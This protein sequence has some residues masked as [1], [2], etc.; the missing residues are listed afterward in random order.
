MRGRVAAI[1]ALLAVASGGAQATPGPTEGFPGHLVVCGGGGEPVEVRERFLAE[2]GGPAARMVVIPTASARADA[3]DAA[4]VFTDPWR[5]RGV[6]EV[7][8]LHT[9]D[10]EVADTEAFCAPL[11][12]ATAVWMSGGQQSRLAAAYGGTR[13]ERE[14]LAVLARGGV[15]GGTSAGAAVQSPTMIEQGNPEPVIATGFALLPGTI[16]DQHF[17]QRERQPRLWAALAQHPDLVG[18]GI[19]ERTALVVHGRRATVLGE[20]TVSVFLADAGARPRRERAVHRG[21]VLDLVQLR[22]AARAR[23]AD[24]PFPA[25][26]VAARVDGPGTL[27]MGG[28]GR[29]PPAVLE[30]FVAAAGGS[31][32]RIVVVPTAAGDSFDRAA[33][34]GVRSLRAAGAT[35]VTAWHVT[36]RAR[37]ADPESTAPLRAATGI[38]FTGGR[39]WRLV[40]AYDGT[41]ALEAFRDVLRRGGA[42]GGSS[43]G[44]SIQAEVMVRGHPLGNR[45]MLVE[46]YARGFAFLR[47]AAVDQHFSQRDREPD[48]RGLVEAHP[49]VLGLGVDESTALVVQG[50]T[51]EVVGAHGVT[52]LDARGGRGL[53]RTRREAGARFDLGAAGR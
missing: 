2:A 30:R 21:S 8:L 37:L 36:D 1:A 11:R 26:P 6:A 48:L 12:E 39:Q 47:G 42:I 10:R 14:L 33:A 13:V 3:D 53:R 52:V 50:T 16:I 27:V 31:E 34:A 32:A 49:Q 29:L 43:A 35:H 18:L 23:A 15:V 44:T 41:A 9:R 20:G 22:R 51:A 5:A 24:R 25:A 4:R 46:G 7:T 38:W 28:G 45:A 40:D 19:D 17:R